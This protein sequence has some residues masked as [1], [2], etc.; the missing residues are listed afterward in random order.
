MDLSTVHGNMFFRSTSYIKN[1]YSVNKRG[2]NDL[3]RSLAPF[4]T[5]I[6]VY[7]TFISVCVRVC[8]C[9]CVYIYIYIWLDFPKGAR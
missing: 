6:S 5:N 1:M 8:V 7:S 3:Q 2:T 9:L 4:I